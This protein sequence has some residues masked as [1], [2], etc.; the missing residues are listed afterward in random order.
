MEVTAPQRFGSLTAAQVRSLDAAATEL[1]V[2]ILQLME[3][4]G[5]QV[6]RMAWRMIGWRPRRV[7]VVAGHGNNG[8]DALVAARHLSSWGCAVTVAVHG[9]LSRGVVVHQLH[10]A[11]RTGVAAVV[12]TD[13]DV[14]VAPA[15][16]ALLVDGLL[17]TGLTGAPRPA[18]AAVIELMRGSILSIDV[19]S[20]LDSDDG[21]VAGAAVRANV[22][23]TLTACKRGMW[24]DGV[25]A[26][27]GVIHVA[28]IGMP[29]QAWLRCGLVPPSGVGGGS[30][31][32][33]PP[34]DEAT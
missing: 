8:G 2:D 10:A 9:E 21:T 15:G 12:S 3:L 22:T 1:G 6:A 26:W 27:T 18:H 25:R 16:A 28:D 30:L 34:Q 5:F 19:P 17:G 4:A 31:R 7:H 29:R 23:C 20:G 11:E 33:V 24:V 14:S 32:L 13:P